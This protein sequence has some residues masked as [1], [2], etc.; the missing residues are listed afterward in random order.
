[1]S[2]PTSQAAAAAQD[3]GIPF[4]LRALTAPEV[5]LLLGQAP[6]TVLEKLATRP[7]FPKRVSTSP[8]T[9][10][11]ESSLYLLDAS[12]V[13]FIEPDEDGEP[14]GRRWVCS[15]LE[16]IAKTRDA[17]SEGWGRLLK[18]ND[19][20]GVT[21][22]WAA[23]S[24]LLIGDGRDFARELA[25]RGLEL[26]PGANAI[27]RLMAYVMTEPAEAR[28]RSLS[29]P[30]WFGRQ[31][32]L[33]NGDVFGNGSEPIVYQHSGGVAVAYGCAG[34]WKAKVSALCVGNSRLVFAVSIMFA[35][36]MLRLVGVG[37]G[38]FHFVGNSSSGKSTLLK[39]AASVA[40]P[41]GY[42]REWRAT[43]NALEGSAVLHNDATLILDEISQVD[44]QQ[45]GEAV[46]ML[47]NGSGKSRSNRAGDA[48]PV[49]TWLVQ[50]ISAGEV[51]LA[52][53][54]AD[55]G[56]KIRAG[57]AVRLVDIPSDAGCGL[58][59]FESLHGAEASNSFAVHVAMMAAENFGTGW[60]AWLEY[61][62]GKNAEN[63]ILHMRREVEIFQRDAVPEK[64]DGQVYRVA[65]RFA[66]AGAAG[67]LATA[68]G[69]TGWPA[70]E[71]RR[72]ALRCFS[73]WLQLRG[74]SENG[75]H[76]ALL[77]Q[78]RAFLEAHG[79]SR[80]EEIAS[81]T[82][83]PIINRAGFLRHDAIHGMQYLVMRETF[84][85]E[86]C[87]G[88]SPKQAAKWL[89]AARWL[90]PGSNGNNTQTIRIKQLGD[91]PVRLYA[92]NAAAVH[93]GSVEPVSAPADEP[94]PF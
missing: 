50:T 83:R 24:Y 91:T 40:G 52:Q 35:G 93:G 4:E 76:I 18:W 12:G 23:P 79:Q 11:A 87:K 46:Y 5:A 71:A 13:W 51:T 55:S 2:A 32:V 53:H 56:K 74:G 78:V 84:K 43:A 48:R 85:N 34:D 29:A 67:E 63:M 21:H 89:A 69:V 75:E 49:A 57:Q 36:P 58:G 64:A 44:G 15:P 70:G 25:G 88:F 82:A 22:T 30:G 66:I 41:P 39:V 54:M 61:I 42:V 94:C 81:D 37:G 47:A 90:Q 38:G 80:F 8:A 92:F 6:R 16:V 1:M 65:A 77:S 45:A 28:A 19:S 20:D 7:D 33:P 62:A 73:D 26:A 27:R 14:S 60:R 3:G 17:N 86:L 59:A 72:A 9:W 10:V 68:A 31:Y